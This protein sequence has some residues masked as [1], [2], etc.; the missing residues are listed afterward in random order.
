MKASPLARRLA[1]DLGVTLSGIA[2]SGPGGR[3]VRRDVEAA[4]QGAVATPV[5]A[6]APAAWT[7]DQAEYEDVWHLSPEGH[8]VT[9]GVLHGFLLDEGLW[10]ARDTGIAH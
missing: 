9:A 8:K 5:Q 6:P 2:G 7:P 1:A 4:K 10:P 3:I